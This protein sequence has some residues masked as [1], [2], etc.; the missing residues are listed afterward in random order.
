MKCTL[1]LLPIL[2][3]LPG[4]VIGQSAGVPSERGSFQNIQVGEVEVG[5]GIKLMQAASIALNPRQRNTHWPT[6][7]LS[8]K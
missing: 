7:C 2:V 5:F 1:I 4:F 8:V 6:L 3:L